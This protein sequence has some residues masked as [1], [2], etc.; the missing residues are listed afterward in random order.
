MSSPVPLE[1]VP[2]IDKLDSRPAVFYEG[3]AAKYVGL[4]LP[5]FREKL[6]NAG[7]INYAEHINGTFRIYRRSELD[8]Y[9]DGLNWRKMEKRKVSP[10][11]LV[12]N[13]AMS[14]CKTQSGS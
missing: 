12:K 1:L 11:A 3:G 2:R 13:G 9:L 4:S 6:V 5:H 7:L 14:E 8:A 10:L